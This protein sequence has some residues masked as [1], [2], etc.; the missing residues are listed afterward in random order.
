MGINGRSAQAPPE[1]NNSD[2]HY[3]VDA[4]SLR[5]AFRKAALSQLKK[6]YT[7]NKLKLCGK[8]EY[9][10]D[11]ICWKALCNELAEVDWV[12]FIQPPPTKTSTAEQVVRYLTRYLTG[13]PIS[14][15]RIVAA[16][17]NYVTFLAR[18]GVR[19]AASVSRCPSRFQRW[20][21][22]ADGACTFNLS[23]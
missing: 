1:S 19:V 7:Q 11:E 14:D 9:L 13:G 6:L 10:G 22:C 3:L 4:I 21:S 23:N 15:S 18:E 12:S 2:D 8:F 16:D 5:E 17:T 20:S